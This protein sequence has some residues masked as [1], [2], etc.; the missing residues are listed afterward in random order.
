MGQTDRW[1]TDTRPLLYAGA[2]YTLK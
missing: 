1:T 2:V